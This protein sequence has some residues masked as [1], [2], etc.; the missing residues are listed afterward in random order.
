MIKAIIYV[1][2]R[3]ISL[4]SKPLV[5]FYPSAPKVPLCC[6]RR[7][8]RDP[9]RAHFPWGSPARVSACRLSSFHRPLLC[10]FPSI[11]VSRSV[12]VFVWYFSDN[13]V[14]CL[15]VLCTYSFVILGF[16]LSPCLSVV[17][18][19]LP[20]FVTRFPFSSTLP[21]QSYTLPV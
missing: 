3:P 20:V 10:S 14:F 17:M 13:V 12:S 16:I 9:R 5:S 11:Y 15:T 6:I 8:S 21:P 2:L 19:T 7:V 4:D 18:S 1:L